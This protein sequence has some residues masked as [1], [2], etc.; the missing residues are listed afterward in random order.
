MVLQFPLDAKIS[1]GL[2]VALVQDHLDRVI[3]KNQDMVQ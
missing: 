1:T 3:F 2:A